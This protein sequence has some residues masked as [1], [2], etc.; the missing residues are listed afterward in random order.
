MRPFQQVGRRAARSHEVS[1][2]F[3][4]KN[5]R[6]GVRRQ[7][8]GAAMGE[9]F[10]SQFRIFIAGPSNLVAEVF[11]CP[12]RLCSF[13]RALWKNKY[14]KQGYVILQTRRRG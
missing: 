13:G 6:R 10:G 11:F 4:V 7:P 1:I 5:N 14:H 12:S 8:G 2:P 9:Q 3:E